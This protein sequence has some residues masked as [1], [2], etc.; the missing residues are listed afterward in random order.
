MAIFLAALALRGLYLHELRD[1][2]PF[3]TL[4][5]DGR[6][7][8]GW[9]QRIAAGDWLGH[10]VFYQ[11]PLYPYFLAVIYKIGGHHVMLARLLQAV[12]GAT[13]CVLLACA[14]R[15]FVS[16]RVGLLAGALLAIYPPAIFFDGLIQKA[17]LD[18]WLVSLLLALLG[19]FLTRRGGAWLAAV[20]IAFGALLLNR[21]NARLLYPVIALWL[22]LDFR[23][24]PLARRATWLAVFT[25]AAA[26]V[27]LPVGWR[28]YRV[29]G[30]FALTTAQ[31]GPNFYI[32]NHQGASGRY[33]SLVPGHGDP[34]HERADATR[35]AEQALG[36]AL[37]P[38]E[39][40]D[41]WLKRAFDY[42]RAQ[43]GDWLRL[44]VWKV[45]LVFSAI[46][47]VDAEGIEVFA[48]FSWLLRGL[49]W[50]LNFG[51]LCPLAVL[52]MWAT[53]RQ[54]RRVALLY[55]MLVTL[56]ASIAIFFVFAR[57]RFS[58]VP[59]MVLFAAAGLDALPEMIRSARAGTWWRQWGPGLLLALA[60]AIPANWP[61]PQL[62]DVE[63]TWFTLGTGLL[64]DKR[65]GDAA[66][67]FE[68]AIQ[69][70]PDFAAAY[71][72]RGLALAEERKDE[73]AAAQLALALRYDPQLG[74]AHWLLGR[75]LIRARRLDEAVAHFRQAVKLRP[76]NELAAIELARSLRAEGDALGAAGELR[77]A[78]ARMP[79]ATLVGNELAWILATHPDPQVRHGAEA[80]TV[81]EHTVQKRA[82]RERGKEDAGL[83]DTL[84]AAYAEAGRY[85][86]A[87]ATAR[88]ALELARAAG[89]SSLAEDVASRL[90]LYESGQ[91]FHEAGH[92]DAGRDP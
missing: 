65:F 42:I 3:S 5:T 13:S 44:L 64:D 61:L 21:E 69:V 31:V 40:S 78:H 15:R 48:Q 73:E 88:R 24:T 47:L 7:Y 29:G 14:G 10:E 81:A 25:A 6:E 54:W 16:P 84:A 32:G 83:L 55:A 92:A 80:V 39:V 82:E 70:K 2:L 77:S 67:A 91:P 52:G 4:V 18:L 28:N 56:A 66:V 49:G 76:D 9:A 79:N 58:M 53:R 41:Y 51:V 74:E 72:N 90:R 75:Y 17:S 60:A 11:A 45:F 50:F 19:E 57:Y 89:N 36:R 22:L 27:L 33:E 43:P 71:Y 46:E 85:A 59:I 20:G 8:D 62:R 26:A 30:E 34:L 23:D 12:L 1:A 68:K 86:D 63:V 87:V 35:L 38:G 37:S